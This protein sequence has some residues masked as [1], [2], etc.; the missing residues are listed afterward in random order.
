[1]PLADFLGRVAERL[2]AGSLRYAGEPAS[3][4]RV[5]AVCGGAGSDLTR[6][7]LASGADAYVT[8]DV[9]YHRFFDV[10][11][12]DGRPRMAL[13]DPGHYET[14]R[15]TEALLQTWLAERFSAVNW[16]RTNLRTSPVETFVP[17]GARTS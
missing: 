7:A 8:A 10:L 16:L 13:V 1:M 4:V 14:E 6:Q 15:I 5:V 9:I 17:A 3:D 12:A 2:E 11:G